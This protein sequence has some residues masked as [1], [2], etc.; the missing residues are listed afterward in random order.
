[1]TVSLCMIVKNEEAVLARCLE[2]AKGL[3]DECVIADTGSTDGTE[4]VARRYTPH[5]IKFAWR[6]DFAA[7]RNAVFAEATGDYLLWLDADDVFPPSAAEKFPKV[8]KM[9]ETERPDTVMCPYEADGVRYVRERIVKR[10]TEAKW[11][12]HVHE[13]IL[14]FGKIVQEG[15]LVCHL[16]EHRER[17]TR[18]L[19]IYRKWAQEEQLSGRDLFYYG[20]ELSY[21][22]L[23]AEAEAVLERMLRGEGWYVN[24]IEACKILSGCLY[25]ENRLDEALSALFRSFLYGEPRASVLCGI[26]AIFKEKKQYREAAFWYES[27]LRARDH[28]QEGDFELPDCRGIVPT[29]ELVWLYHVLGEPSKSRAMHKKSEALAPDHPSVVYNRNYFKE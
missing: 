5:V 20:R 21:H 2:S 7:A 1:M 3:Y 12:G 10:C 9:L 25:A 6:D 17:G 24:K 16:P 13:C 19:D 23:Y 22:K 14:P 4:E 15:L 29:L 18:N 11:R 28:M 8:R 26:G 27:A